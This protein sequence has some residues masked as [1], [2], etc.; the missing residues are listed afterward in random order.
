MT[1][2]RWIIDTDFSPRLP[3]YTR[4][5]ANDVLSDPI[6]PLGAS[7]AWIPQI[8][9][10]WGY[11]YAQTGAYEITDFAHPNGSGAFIYGYL[12][13]NL[14]ATRLFGIRS[15]VGIE[16]VDSIWFGGHPDLPPHQADPRDDNAE[17][18]ANVVKFAEWAMT[19]T[20]YPELEEDKRIAARLRAE[21]PDLAAITDAALIA[22]ARSVMPYERL[23]WRGEV[24]GGVGGSIGPGAMAGLLAD[25]DPTLMVKLVAQAG[26]V[27]SAAPAFALWDLSRLVRSDPALTAEFDAGVPG[28]LG[29]ITANHPGFREA[30]DGFIYEFGY[31]G[32][33]EW[34]LGSDSWETKPELPLALIERLRM[35]DED[36]S[37]QAR[38]AAQ[39]RLGDEALAEA[40]A[41]VGG[42][43]TAQ[44]TLRAAVASA[45]RFA[46]WRERGKSNC[47]RVLHEARVAL[48]E[49][50]RR[51]HERGLLERPT[52]IFMA[53]DAE[54]DLLDL[55][56]SFLLPT[57]TAREEQWRA[58]FGLDLPL[59]ID[60]SEPIPPVESLKH[61]THREVTAALPGDV[62]S[63][64]GVSAGVARG[65]ACVVLSPDEVGEMEPGDIL[66]AP[67]TDPSW[68]PL[69]VV[70]GAV[71]VDVGATNSHAMI[72]SRELGIPCVAGLS[73]ATR[74]IPHGALIEVDGA[75]GT[76]TIIDA[77][78]PA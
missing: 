66:V 23:A 50:G 40:L 26:D 65:R 78:T 33:N 5:N 27:D 68:T 76:V 77:A 30:F 38:A 35:L 45:H 24:L 17:C 16:V 36:A 49:L 46:G 57:L 54:L 22:R 52:Q 2:S 56:T 51:L 29:R 20:D 70:A 69:F 32:P 47:I 72:V 59:F 64:A 74:T 10:G 34:D 7:M 71:V 75:A 28:L 73:D 41:H 42:D 25:A 9:Q 31:R 53:M 6:T 12:Y 37:P 11:G 18:T 4:M 39:K 61:L 44:A 14:S 67:Q 55:D 43:E 1:G 60:T 13:V 21:R 19:A 3:V 63:A 8:F 48:M 58:L 15:G 62:L